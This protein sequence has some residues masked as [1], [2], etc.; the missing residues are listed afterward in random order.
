MSK[1][2]SKKD[3]TNVFLPYLI[4]QV[5]YYIELFVFHDSCEVQNKHLFDQ[6]PNPSHS[7]LLNKTICK[8][9]LCNLFWQFCKFLFQSNY[10]TTSDSEYNAKLIVKRN[11]QNKIIQPIALGVKH[12]IWLENFWPDSSLCTGVN[13]IFNH[14]GHH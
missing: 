3:Q 1:K 5:Y 2:L 12:F 13:N 11:L 10:F 4:I 8:N 9:V 14:Q 7:T 6:E